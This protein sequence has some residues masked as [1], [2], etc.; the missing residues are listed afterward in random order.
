MGREKVWPVLAKIVSEP[1]YA[2]RVKRPTLPRDTHQ[3]LMREL[4]VMALGELG[5]AEQHVAAL[6]SALKA[7]P[8]SDG[9]E[10]IRE[11]LV[12]ALHRL[13]KTAALDDYVRKMT[14]RA[15]KEFKGP[16]KA[17]GCFALFSVALVQGRV[18]RRDDAEATYLRHE[19]AV[20]E[21]K[22]KPDYSEPSVAYNLACLYALKGEKGKAMTYLRKAVEEG[23]HHKEWIQRDGDLDSIRGEDA[24]RKLM[25]DEKLFPGSKP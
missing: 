3:K 24:Y 19:R 8:E 2:F 16:V 17:E 21:Y 4:A 18:G 1:A 6:E 25:S 20:D 23:F 10:S 5:S 14:E 11:E 12:V 9:E 7:L 13:G 15:E 22:L